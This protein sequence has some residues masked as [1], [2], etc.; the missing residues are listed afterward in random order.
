MEIEEAL[1]LAHTWLKSQS[2]WS[3]ENDAITSVTRTDGTWVVGHTSRRWL[4]TGDELDIPI[5]AYGPVVIADDG[6]I[7][8]AEGCICADWTRANAERTVNELIARVR[9]PHE[10]ES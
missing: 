1:E 7:S 3:D 6:Q 8:G 4:Q 9:Q 5:G 10:H 2:W